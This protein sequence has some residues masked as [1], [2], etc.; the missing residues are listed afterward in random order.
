MNEFPQLRE[1]PIFKNFEGSTTYTEIF[2]PAI[3][4]AR[5]GNTIGY[6]YLAFV[7]N[8]YYELFSTDYPK[9]FP[10]MKTTRR[11]VMQDLRATCFTTDL[12]TVMEFYK[13]FENE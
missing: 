2:G 8:R 10:N 5:E 6:D 9:S 1:V 12:G 4:Y 13:E 7:I 3:K 11:R